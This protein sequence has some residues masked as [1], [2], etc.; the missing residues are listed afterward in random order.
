MHFPLSLNIHVT[1]LCVSVQKDYKH[2]FIFSSLCNKVLWTTEECW[3]VLTG[4]GDN[5]SCRSGRYFKQHTEKMFVSQ[6][7][8]WFDIYNA[9]S[10]DVENSSPPAAWARGG[11]GGV[12]SLSCDTQQ[13]DR[14]LYYTKEINRKKLNTKQFLYQGRS[15]TICVLFKND[16]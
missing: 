5:T 9:F 2:V 12:T 10:P 11:G 4:G 14:K 7:Y 3:I 16:F 1:T 8:F 15:F 6:I 13:D